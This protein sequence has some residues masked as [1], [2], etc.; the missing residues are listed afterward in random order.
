MTMI[1]PNEFI[2]TIP[3]DVEDEYV[4]FAP[5]HKLAVKISQNAADTIH[6]LIEHGY[7]SFQEKSKNENLISNFFK[8]HHLLELP[9]KWKV[10][11]SENTKELSRITLALTNKCNLRCSYCYA[12]GGI[13][14]TSMSFDTVR[15]G[16]DTTIKHANFNKN[17]CIYVKFHG[18]G[19]AFVEYEL[20]KKSVDYIIRESNKNALHP[21]LRIVT[22]LTLITPRIA[23]WLKENQIYVTASLDGKRDIQNIQRPNA[24]G[25]GSYNKAIQGLLEL[26]KAGV[27]FEIRATV[28]NESVSYMVDFVKFLGTEIFEEG[29]GAIH[30]EPVAICGRANQS[31]L[32]YVNPETYFNNYIQ[33]PTKLES[34]LELTSF[35][36]SIL[37]IVKK[38]AIVEQ[39]SAQ[40]FA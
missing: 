5:L 25:H 38:Y 6:E 15:D 19:E 28:T 39:V 11:T 1:Q 24:N 35:A 36:H 27:Q 3:T 12:N 30:F 37:S 22:N 33:G 16:I 14:Q 4:L 40:C 10:K 32:E 23:N 18:G 7:D 8:K 2:F 31:A 13:D 20:L 34:L 29:I 26:K 9:N 17:N 21:H